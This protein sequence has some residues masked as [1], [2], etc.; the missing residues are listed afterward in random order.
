MIDPRRLETGGFLLFLALIT[1]GLAT[2]VSGFAG[3]LLWATLAAILFQSL[4]RWL[5]PR[6]GGRRNAAAASI[7][8]S[9]ESGAVPPPQQCFLPLW[10]RP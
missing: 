5:L 10:W 7:R 4:F 2:I 1:I 9:L 3:A 8:C 6:I